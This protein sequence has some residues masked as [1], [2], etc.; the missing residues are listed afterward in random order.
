MS[1]QDKKLAPDELLRRLFLGC[2]DCPAKIGSL[3]CAL[4]CDGKQKLNP[5]RAK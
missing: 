4:G 3:D 5:R 1:E 2:G